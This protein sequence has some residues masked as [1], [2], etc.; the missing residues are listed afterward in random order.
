M[1][2]SGI[3]N[4]MA[5]LSTIGS[6]GGS[7]GTQGASG[8]NL[9]SAS[10]AI[11][12]HMR[13]TGK[14]AVDMNDLY[15]MASDSSL[16]ETVRDAAKFMLQNPDQYSQLET[17]DVAGVDGKS[18]VGNFDAAAQGLIGGSGGNGIGQ[19]SGMGMGQP[20][21]VGG[22]GS[23]SGFGS[24]IDQ[25]QGMT[26]Q[27]AAGA[28]AGYMNQHD[29][30]SMDPNELYK[31][32]MNK[33]GNVPPMVQEAARTMLAN[34]EAL[35]NMAGADGK[36]GAEEAG[37]AAQ[38]LAGNSVT[39]A[40]NKLN[41]EEFAEGS[42]VGEQLAGK[43]WFGDALAGMMIRDLNN[44]PDKMQNFVDRNATTN[45]VTTQNS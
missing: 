20:Q 21:G 9:Q 13:E 7:Q 39:G 18:G 8:M 15:K 22:F 25:G 6:V 1:N 44:N 29:I 45:S 19:Q 14:D 43:G 30:S 41:H 28:L 16:P 33:D 12:G 24:G 34:P 36:L 31:L 35:Q 10:G 32:A 11:A 17:H 5:M 2:V 26:P 4:P 23:P 40:D 38:G 42:G 37:N 27:S 3:A